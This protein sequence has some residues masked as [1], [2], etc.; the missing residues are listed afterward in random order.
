[1]SQARGAAETIAWWTEGVAIPGGMG[2]LLKWCTT[3]CC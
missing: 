2:E 3:V 1:M